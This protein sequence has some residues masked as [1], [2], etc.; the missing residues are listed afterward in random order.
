M[1]SGTRGIPRVIRMHTI[2]P[3]IAIWPAAF[4]YHATNDISKRLSLQPQLRWKN[5]PR[6]RWANTFSPV[7]QKTVVKGWTLWLKW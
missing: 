5:P 6:A 4:S 7:L 2:V 3:I 1:D